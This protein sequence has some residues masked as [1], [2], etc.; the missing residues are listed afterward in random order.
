MVNLVVKLE[1]KMACAVLFCPCAVPTS[2]RLRLPASPFH[3]AAF[4]ARV[5]LDKSCVLYF[6]V[7]NADAFF[8]NLPLEFFPNPFSNVILSDVLAESPD[9]RV[10]GDALRE[11]QEL[12]KAEAVIYLKLQLFIADGV[13]AL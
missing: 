6:S 12:L 1:T 10:V 4:F 2:A 8:S 13:P 3:A 7:P 5:R 11:I 9:S